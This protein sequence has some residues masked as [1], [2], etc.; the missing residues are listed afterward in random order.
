MGTRARFVLVAPVIALLAILSAWSVDV[1]FAEQPVW[2]AT[3]AVRSWDAGARPNV[4]DWDRLEA[5]LLQAR[6]VIPENRAI[7]H[8]LGLLNLWRFG[9]AKYPE[10][11]LANL[12]QAASGWP[13]WPYTWGNLLDARYRLGLTRAPFD[14][15]LVTAWRLGPQEPF[16]QRIVADRGLALWD[17][18]GEEPRGVV[19]AAVAAGMRR[20]PKDMLGISARRGRLALACAHV[21]GDARLA[22]SLW[23]KV[24]GAQ[25]GAGR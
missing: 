18:L 20:D 10:A 2:F 16:I 6:E 14:R 17:E 11:A 13:T 21:Q 4:A 5:G 24:C 15:I 9:S 1:G 19:K 7:H 8:W 12:T 23:P 22:Q 25:R 3:K